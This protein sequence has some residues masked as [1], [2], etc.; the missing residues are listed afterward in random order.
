MSTIDMRKAILHGVVSCPGAPGKVR[1]SPLSITE[2]PQAVTAVGHETVA[3]AILPRGST[4]SAVKHQ[5]ACSLC[6][7]RWPRGSVAS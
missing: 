2:I 7:V 4:R 6:R 5:N 3:G 1:S